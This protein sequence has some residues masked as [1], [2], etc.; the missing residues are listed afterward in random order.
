MGPQ[1]ARRA[2]R[3]KEAIEVLDSRRD[4]KEA[5]QWIART[6]WLMRRMSSRRR[7]DTRGHYSLPILI[8]R[9]EPLPVFINTAISEEP[10]SVGVVKFLPVEH[11]TETPTVFEKPVVTLVEKVPPHTCSVLPGTEHSFGYHLPTYD[12]L[13]YGKGRCTTRPPIATHVDKGCAY[14]GIKE[15]ERCKCGVG[16]FHYTV[17]H[18]EECPGGRVHEPNG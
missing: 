9:D 10:V 14:C 1:S 8:L 2:I 18:Q 5:T 16:G 12:P 7:K 15:R 6:K 11:D 13:S 3:G 17:K 4:Y